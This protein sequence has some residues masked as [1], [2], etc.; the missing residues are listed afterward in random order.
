MARNNLARCERAQWIKDQKAARLA[1]YNKGVFDSDTAK[2]CRRFTN[3]NWYNR[4]YAYFYCVDSY[5]EEQKQ[6]INMNNYVG[7]S[8]GKLVKGSGYWDSC[9]GTS[10]TK[11]GVLHAKC[12][13]ENGDDVD[14]SIDIKTLLVWKGDFLSKK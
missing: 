8:N 4:K 7:N 10:I 9:D 12:E 5:K 3:G 14:T 6:K 2:N 11:A 13:N 1:K